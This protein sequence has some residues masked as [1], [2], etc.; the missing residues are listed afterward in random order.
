M[1]GRGIYMP[2]GT[3]LKARL[4][5]IAL[6]R[7]YLGGKDIKQ[8]LRENT[9]ISESRIYQVLKRETQIYMNSVQPRLL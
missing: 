8:I 2:K 5:D 4:R 6:F 1:G 3:A 9:D 7:E